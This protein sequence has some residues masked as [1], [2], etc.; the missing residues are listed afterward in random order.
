VPWWGEQFERLI[1]LM[2]SAFYKTVGQGLLSWGELSEVI[3]DIEV[4]MNNCPLCYL[5]GG[6]QFPNLT[7]NTMLFLNSDILPELQ[8][9]QLEGRVL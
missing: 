2:K 6:V 8:P 9:Y 4:T 1:G 3:L 7:P 5:E